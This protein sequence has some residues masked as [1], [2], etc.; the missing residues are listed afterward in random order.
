MGL[1]AT[2]EVA[3]EIFEGLSNNTASMSSD[4]IADITASINI[5]NIMASASNNIALQEDIFPVSHC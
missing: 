5:M 1:G 4:N 2:Q 3:M